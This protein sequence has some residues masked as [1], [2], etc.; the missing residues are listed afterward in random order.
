M[1]DSG[2]TAQDLSLAIEKYTKES[3]D[4]TKY[5]LLLSEL[6]MELT[7]KKG[8]FRPVIAPLKLRQFIASQLSGKV[9]VIT[10]PRQA[11][12]I[13]VIPA[14]EEFSFVERGKVR[15]EV[16]LGERLKPT[17]WA[18]FVKP[19]APGAVRFLDIAD[20]GLRFQDLPAGSTPPTAAAREV[21]RTLIIDGQGP[22]YDAREV[23]ARIKQWAADNG[24]PEERLVN[25]EPRAIASKNAFFEVFKD[26]SDSD[27]RRIEIPFDI[28]VKLAYR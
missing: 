4:K 26:L 10:H 12:K 21:P 20:S 13:A 25:R 14:G 23:V 11:Q 1:V 2:W 5:P 19:L 28:I 22:D 24:L 17:I 15:T 6:G 27:L 18:A 3:W 8:D 7:K 9:V 16:D